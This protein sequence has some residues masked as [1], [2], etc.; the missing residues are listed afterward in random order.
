MLIEIRKEIMEKGIRIE[1]E[2]EGMIVK[3]VRMRSQRWRIRGIYI[4][5]NMEEMLQSM[6]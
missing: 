3:N 1:I 2:R 5:K 6:A 4:N